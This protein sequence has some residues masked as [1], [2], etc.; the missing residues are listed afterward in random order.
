MVI[1]DLASKLEKLDKD[2][3]IMAKVVSVTNEILFVD[4]F[5]KRNGLPALHLSD[6]RPLPTV[7]KCRT[8]LKELD[9]WLNESVNNQPESKVYLSS[10]Y[11]YEDGS[12]DFRYF[13]LKDIVQDNDQ[14]ILI[15]NDLESNNLR[16]H[17]DAFDEN[18]L[19]PD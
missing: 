17:F 1:G 4:L 7:K 6:E 18:M 19:D 8:L 12:Y 5:G 16:E 13:K 9:V 3:P 10:I 15:G 2:L 11:D 14:I